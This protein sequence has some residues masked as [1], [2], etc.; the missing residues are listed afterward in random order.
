[1]FGIGMPELI[2]ILAVAL[3][4]IGPKKLPDLARSLGKALNEFKS[5]TQDVRDSINADAKEIKPIEKNGPGRIGRH[6]GTNISEKE[7]EAVSHTE[8]EPDPAIKTGVPE[9]DD[10]AAESPEETLKNNE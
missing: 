6:T 9:Y 3:I 2:L 8:K 5:V 4:V 7:A 10:A 1:M